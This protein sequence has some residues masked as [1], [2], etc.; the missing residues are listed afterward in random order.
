M[1]SSAAIRSAVPHEIPMLTPERN[2]H[3]RRHRAHVDVEW[4]A[5]ETAQEFLVRLG[6][7]Y[8]ELIAQLWDEERHK[9]RQPIEVA[10]NGAVLGIHHRLDSDLHAGEASLLVPQYQGVD[11]RPHCHRNRS[12]KN[13]QISVHAT[14]N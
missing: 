11:R 7:A 8:P 5:G 4:R 13:R 9:L 14:R 6:P 12:Q 1:V 2:S 10:V 3:D